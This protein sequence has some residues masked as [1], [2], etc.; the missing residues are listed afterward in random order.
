MTPTVD[1]IKLA[2][3]P[4]SLKFL[5]IILGFVMYGVALDINL[6]DLKRILKSPKAP[7][8]GLICQFFIMFF[9]CYRVA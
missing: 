5:N 6:D 7:A 8:I 9:A 1:E 4:E 3:N 2:F